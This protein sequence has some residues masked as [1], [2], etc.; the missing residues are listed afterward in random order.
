MTQVNK[1]IY[2]DEFGD[3]MTDVDVASVHR[4]TKTARIV[5][6]TTEMTVFVNEYGQ[7]TPIIIV[8]EASV[9]GRT[10]AA[11]Y[12][13]ST[14]KRFV[15]EVV[16]QHGE[17][18]EFRD[19]DGPDQD[20]E[21]AVMSNYFLGEKV[22][23]EYNINAWYRRQVLRHELSLGRSVVPSTTMKRWEMKRT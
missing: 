5:M 15:V 16:R 21:W 14:R 3:E 17:V 6:N 12:D 9:D 18:K 8:A 22:F 11:L 4:T 13:M 7:Q 23:D 19:L 1:S 2:R 10:Y 20:E